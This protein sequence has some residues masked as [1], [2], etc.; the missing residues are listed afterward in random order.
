MTWAAVVDTVLELNVG[1]IRANS[2][3]TSLG[4][5]RALRVVRLLRLLV[6]VPGTQP[7]AKAISVSMMNVLQIAFMIGMIIL[8]F[9][10]FGTALFRE[11][12]QNIK[13]RYTKQYTNFE[14][15]FNAM[16]LLS[17]LATGDAWSDTMFEVMEGLPEGRQWQATFFFL[18]LQ[19]TIQFLMMNLFV[20]V[21]ED[22]YE[23]HPH[24]PCHPYL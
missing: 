9:A 24:T 22:V 17:V 10:G 5:L 1:G 23:G 15:V 21:I 18:F 16:Q 13:V 11:A 12:A 2:S 8:S 14:N 20:M 7:F 4:F 6:L 19:F 3:C